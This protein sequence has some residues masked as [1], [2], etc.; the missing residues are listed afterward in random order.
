MSFNKSIIDIV[1]WFSIKSFRLTISD[2][3][4]LNNLYSYE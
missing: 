1:I 4:P 3:S 2:T